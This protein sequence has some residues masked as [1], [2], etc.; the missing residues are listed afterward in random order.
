MSVSVTSSHLPYSIL[1]QSLSQVLS[2]E[3]LTTSFLFFF[4]SHSIS[5]PVLS[6]VFLVLIF[7]ASLFSCDPQ[8]PFI[9]SSDWLLCPRCPFALAR[10]GLDT[11]TES[12]GSNI[13]SLKIP[14]LW[15]DKRL[16]GQLEEESLG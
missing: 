9:P 12:L 1:H 11:D 6:T 13:L 5:G 16:G 4:M 8:L 7:F 10:R 3:L 14:V 15:D 2:S